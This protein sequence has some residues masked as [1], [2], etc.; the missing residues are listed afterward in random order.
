VTGEDRMH[1]VVDRKDE[2][3]RA[4]RLRFDAHVKPERTVEGR[5]LVEEEMGQLV[6]EG[7]A[8]GRR[9]EVALRLTPL[10]DRVDHATDQL[11]NAPLALRRAERPAEV[12]RDDDIGGEL[13]PALRHLDVPLL[14]DRLARLAPD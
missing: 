13:R 1:R 9:G 14:E 7:G 6:G 11:A 12:L 8:V 10:P 3:R 4:L 2:A 5:L